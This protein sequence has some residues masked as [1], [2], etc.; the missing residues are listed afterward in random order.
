MTA[1]EKLIVEA[2]NIGA[3]VVEMDLEGESGYCLNEVLFINKNLCEKQKYWILSE[4]I[5][6]FKTTSGDILNLDSIINKKLENAARAESIERVCSLKQIVRAIKNGANDRYEVAEYLTLT[7][8]F[9]DEAIEYHRRKHSMYKE[10]ENIIL[11]FEPGFGVL[12]NDIF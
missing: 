5:G 10:C 8:K 3:V 2:E 7:D 12:R 6:H 4:E 11:Y 9:F 1:Y